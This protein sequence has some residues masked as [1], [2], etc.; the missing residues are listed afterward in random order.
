M[1]IRTKVSSNDTPFADCDF[2]SCHLVSF[3]IGHYDLTMLIRTYCNDHFEFSWIDL[4]LH[5]IDLPLGKGWYFLMNTVQH[6]N[7]P[8]ACE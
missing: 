1:T 3:L 8:L 6:F 7:S 5:L 4:L 2:S